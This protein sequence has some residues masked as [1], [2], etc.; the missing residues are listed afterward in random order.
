MIL[1]NVTINIDSVVEQEWLE[2]MKAEHVP[3]VLGTGMFTECKIYRILADD[4]QGISYSFQYF[5]KSMDDIE[6]YQKNYAAAMQKETL[7]KYGKHFVAFRTLLESV[8]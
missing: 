8:D 3:N 5:A 2:W 7:D 6:T 4:P 1:Y